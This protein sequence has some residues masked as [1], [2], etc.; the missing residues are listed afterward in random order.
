MSEVLRSKVHISDSEVKEF[1]EQHKLNSDVRK[2]FIAE[3]LISTSSNASQL[4]SKL[5][6]ELRAGAAESVTGQKSAVLKVSYNNFRQEFRWKMAEKLAGFRKV[7]LI[8]KFMQ[9]FLN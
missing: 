3:I 2:F 9:Q 7:I 5:V 8:Q 6:G 4:A 1:F